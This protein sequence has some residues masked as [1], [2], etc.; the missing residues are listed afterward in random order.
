MIHLTFNAYVNVATARRPIG[1][2]AGLQI[3]LNIN[4]PQGGGKIFPACNRE[5]ERAALF[6][7]IEV[8]L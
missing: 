6:I 8:F 1:V 7:S 5:T 3:L 2:M 4:G